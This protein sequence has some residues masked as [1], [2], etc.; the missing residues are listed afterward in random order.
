MR[1]ALSSGDEVI[2]YKV[3]LCQRD[4]AIYA[5]MLVAGIVFALFRDNIKP[6]PLLVWLLIGIVPIAVDGVHN[7]SQR[8]PGFPS[9]FARAHPS[10]AP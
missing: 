2:G 3:A 9:P 4:V 5:A 10:C 6:L 1:R 7:F 8:C